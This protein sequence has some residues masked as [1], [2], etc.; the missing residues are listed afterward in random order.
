MKKMY[1][2]FSVLV[3][4]LIAANAFAQ[5]PT[6][7]SGWLKDVTST[8]KMGPPK[9]ANVVYV[10]DFNNDNYPDVVTMHKGSSAYVGSTPDGRDMIQLYMNIQDTSSANPSHRMFLDVTVGSGVNANPNPSDTGRHSTATAFADINNDG[11]IDMVTGNYYHRIENYKD[12]MDRCEVLLGDGT[13]KFTLVPNNGLHELGL[14]NP[15]GFSF[16]DYDR[17]G[18]LDLFVAVWF[19]NY[20]ANQY[21]ASY[22]MRGNGDGTFTN[23]T[24]G[25]GV[26]SNLEPLYGVSVVDWNNDCYPDIATSPYCRT[27]GRLLRNNGNSTF[28]DVAASKG[29][30][31]KLNGDF[32]G[33]SYQPTCM[34]GTMID[35][36]DND[37]DMDF[38]FPLVHGGNDANEFHTMMMQNQGPLTGYGLVGKMNLLT[39]DAPTSSHHGDYDA[40]FYDLD[41]NGYDDAVLCQGTYVPATDR[42]YFWMQDT[43]THIMHDMTHE[44]GFIFGSIIGANIKNTHC[45]EP[46]DFDLDGDDDLVIGTLTPSNLPEIKFFQNDIGHTK[47]WI[48]VKLDVP[49]ASTG[50]NRSAIGA[51]IIVVSGGHRITKEIFAGRGNAGGQQPFIYNFGLDNRTTVDSIIVSWPAVGCPKTIVYNPT[52]NQMITVTAP[53][54]TSAGPARQESIVELKIY[55]NPAKNNL[56]TQIFGASTIEKV[57]LFNMLG[58][59]M[60]ETR[61]YL[62]QTAVVITDV[63]KL[64]AGQYVVKVTYDK[65]QT[66]TQRFVKA[67]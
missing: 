13:G 8:V 25:S 33:T 28:T 50:I 63:S 65:G 16:L 53:V 37:G 20:T 51:K 64:A 49:A 62:N 44:L 57:E 2:Y 45:V 41:N 22:L 61:T 34:F 31:S 14:I 59:Y 48:A 6:P 35:D 9:S 1:T 56:V 52:I 26:Q 5:I 46:L 3:S 38:L 18:I 29:Y 32:D 27:G 12:T 39:W 47:N 54:I 58:Q 36:Y 17:N 66:A 40:A 30:N 11:F 10:V 7:S 21:Q 55:P 4:I 42:T 43:T 67:D 15:T 60:N 19:K 23:V 24:N